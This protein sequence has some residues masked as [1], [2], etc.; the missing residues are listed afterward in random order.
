MHKV[1]HDITVMEV[2][3]IMKKHDSKKDGYISYDEFKDMIEELN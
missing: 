3:E 1:G 2:H